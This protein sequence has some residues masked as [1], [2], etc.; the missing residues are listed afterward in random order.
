MK[1]LLFSFLSISLFLTS[2]CDNDQNEG[3]GNVITDDRTT[4]TFSTIQVD[5]AFEV[6]IRQG[7]DH[8]VLVS[9]D[10]N[11]I[12]RINTSTTNGV[13]KVTLG[14]GSYRNTT[15]RVEITAPEL[16]H[17]ELGDAIRGEL[18]DFVSANDLSIMIND[19]TKLSMSGS[20]P[21]LELNV[22]DASQVSGFNFTTTN[23][24]TRVRDASRVELTVTDRLEGSLRDASTF[25]FRG[26]PETSVEVSD[27]S[28]V[29]DAN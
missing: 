18:I 3:S 1:Y 25:R 9:S 23:C 12:S 22:N 15:L 8:Q 19:A 29:V 28:S 24:N 17:I 6:T 10:D 7:A 21:N 13:L 2:A 20:A 27:G 14:N 4:S 16:D 5:D 11:I 26:T